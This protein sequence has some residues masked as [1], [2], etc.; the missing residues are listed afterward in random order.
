MLQDNKFAVMAALLWGIN[1]PLVK[2]VLRSVPET[3]FLIIRFSAA[4]FLFTGYLL[5]SGQNF[6]VAREHLGRLL[7][8]GFLGVGVYNIIWTLGIHRTTA[9]NAAILISASPIFTGIYSH[10][11]V[12]GGLD[13]IS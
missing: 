5:F 6:R 4:A 7:L 2:F 13:V 9:A 11:I 10:S 3:D 12:P 1:Y 8:L